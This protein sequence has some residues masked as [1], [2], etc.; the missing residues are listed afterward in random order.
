[1]CSRC[2]CL[3]TV[4]IKCDPFDFS[5]FPGGH[6]VAR[7]WDECCW[8]VT[9]KVKFMHFAN[10]DWQSNIYFWSINYWCYSFHAATVLWMGYMPLRW[11]TK[12]ILVGH[13]SF[14]VTT[15]GSLFFTQFYEESRCVSQFHNSV[16][17]F[18][19]L[20]HATVKFVL[21]IENL[22]AR[23]AV[24]SFPLR[25]HNECI[26]CILRKAWHSEVKIHTLVNVR[27]NMFSLIKEIKWCFWIT[28]IKLQSFVSQVEK[29]MIFSR[30]RV[31]CGW[32]SL[33]KMS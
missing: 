21:I 23:Q 4:T 8:T 3:H 13:S 24:N 16:S 9:I 28:I 19:F 1:M 6:Y 29:H 11:G 25:F 15:F 14:C 26:W 30:Q 27:L 10:S 7:A 32:N 20:C 18:Y 2:H 31:S 17:L 12:N 22:S 33:R 5:W